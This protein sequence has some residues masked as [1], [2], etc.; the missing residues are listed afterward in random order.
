MANA[1]GVSIVTPSMNQGQYLAATLLSVS[2]QTDVQIG[3]YVVDGASTDGSLTVIQQY[4]DQLAYWVSEPDRGQAHAINKGLLRARGDILAWLNADD[5]YLPGTLASV[6]TFFDRHPQ[7]DVVYGDVEFVDV[8]GQRLGTMAAWEF[9]AQLQLC[10]TNLIPQPAAFFRRRVYEL[11]GGLD[12]DLHYALDYDYWCRAVLAGARFQHVPE[13]W[14]T[15]RLHPASKTEAQAD[16]FAAEMR[17]AVDK[18][19]AS[20]KL[21]AAWRRIADSNWEQFRAETALRQARPKEA[22]AH[23]I[24]AARRCPWRL[25]TLSLLAFAASPRLGLWLRRARWRLAGRREQPWH[26]FSV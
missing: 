10:A 26:L 16:R 2:A 12:E 22:Q 3:Y 14:A 15:Y 23:F 24:T 7:V 6:T 11:I 20:G 17:R 25:K 21:P 5:T 4:A 8:A 13:A 19:F 1:T 9:D 18:S